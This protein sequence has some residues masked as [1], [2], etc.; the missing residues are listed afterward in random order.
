M[1]KGYFSKSGLEPR[2]TVASALA[3]ATRH[4]AECLASPEREAQ[5]LLAASLGCPLTRLFADPLRFLEPAE[6]ARVEAFVLRRQRG[7]PLAYLAGHREFWSLDFRVNR[8]TLVPRPE[9]EALI[10]R[11]LELIPGGHPGRLLDLGTGCGVLAIT[12]ARERP[13]LEIWAT[14]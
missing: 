11:A 13:G 14:D 8:H 3:W 6:Q 2:P 12:L 9:T 10:A 1:P 7:E 5:L 4:L